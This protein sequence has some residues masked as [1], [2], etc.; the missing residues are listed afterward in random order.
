MG[1]LKGLPP[2]W[3][4]PQANFATVFRDTPKIRLQPLPVGYPF[5]ERMRHTNRNPH[6]VEKAR[7]AQRFPVPP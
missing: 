3:A 4:D 2:W 6:H 1:N 7:G 5:T